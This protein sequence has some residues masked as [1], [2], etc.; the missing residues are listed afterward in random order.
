MVY[1][2]THKF[3]PGITTHN[4]SGFK[5][6][7]GAVSSMTVNPE[8][9]ASSPLRRTQ[10]SSSTCEDSIC[11]RAWACTSPTSDQRI[12]LSFASELNSVY[13]WEWHQARGPL[14][15]S[16]LKGYLEPGST[17]IFLAW[18][19]L[20]VWSEMKRKG[21]TEKLKIH[22]NWTFKIAEE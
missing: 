16:Y 11:S 17:Q 4:N 10:E 1:E 21:F 9:S 3:V 5:H 22:K 13:W 20:D 2:N 15:E 18:T 6:E 8:N 12:M 19:P 7:D 14:L